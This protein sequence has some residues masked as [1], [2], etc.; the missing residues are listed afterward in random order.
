MTARAAPSKTSTTNAKIAK[1]VTRHAIG[2][3]QKPAVI[4]PLEVRNNDLVL[5]LPPN[6]FG[7]PDPKTTR[8]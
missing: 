3:T 4:G 5:H 2:A 1:A 7:K 8:K 6:F